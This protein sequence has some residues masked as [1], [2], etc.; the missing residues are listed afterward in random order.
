MPISMRRLR[1]EYLEAPSRFASSV[2]G[3]VPNSRSRL[4]VQRSGFVRLTGTICKYL[5]RL[6]IARGSMPNR[7]DAS[8]IVSD[9][10]C[11]SMSV[12]QRV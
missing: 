9:A 3:I 4:A 7:R 12:V 1:I 2:S 10:S 5:R 6:R 8:E 11:S